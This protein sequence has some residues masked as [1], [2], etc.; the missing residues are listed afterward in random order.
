MLK[1]EPFNFFYTLTRNR[2]IVPYPTV[3]INNPTQRIH[4]ISPIGDMFS[5]LVYIMK[6][7]IALVYIFTLLLIWDGYAGWEMYLYEVQGYRIGAES[8]E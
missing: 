1:K 6:V 2:W 4:M 7:D 8:G 3:P 5:V